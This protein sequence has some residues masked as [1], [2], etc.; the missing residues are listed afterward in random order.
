MATVNVIL[1]ATALSASMMAA[2]AV[3]TET[4]WVVR[5]RAAHVRLVILATVIV[6]SRA[7]M[8]SAITTAA[9]ALITQTTWVVGC[10]AIVPGRMLRMGTARLAASM[11]SA[12]TM[13][14]TAALVHL[15]V[16]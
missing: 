2:I 10:R 1:R 6:I 14:E 12:I 13:A 5:L 3:I 7:T 8:R 9:S 16:T 4:T 11:K 15:L